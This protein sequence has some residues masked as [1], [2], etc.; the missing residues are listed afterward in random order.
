MTNPSRLTVVEQVYHQVPDGKST[1]VVSRFAVNLSTP[2]VASELSIT[3]GTEWVRLE[4][5]FPRVSM[6]VV[7]LSK[8]VWKMMPSHEDRA[9][10]ASRRVLIGFS[11]PPPVGNSRTQHSPPVEPFACVPVI[12]VGNGESC[13]F[14]PVGASLVWVR[15]TCPGVVVTV[16]TIPG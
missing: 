14:R 3:V 9:S 11:P 10:E 7:Q 13:R 15:A 5:P 2:A 1:A 8:V 4:S 12:E 16:T 6:L